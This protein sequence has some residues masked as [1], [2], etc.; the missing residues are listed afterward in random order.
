VLPNPRM[1]PTGRR[2]AELRVGGA[3]LERSKERKLVRAPA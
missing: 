2:G 1:Q 3:L